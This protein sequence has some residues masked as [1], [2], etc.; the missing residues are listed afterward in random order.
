MTYVEPQMLPLSDFPHSP[1]T[2]PGMKV[3]EADSTP[4]FGTVYLTMP[5]AVKSGRTLRLQIIL[6][7]REN[8]FPEIGDDVYP[9]IFYVQGSAWHEQELGQV[10]PA[11]ADFARRGYVIAIVEYRPSE[12]APFPAQAKDVKRVDVA[13]DTKRRCAGVCACRLI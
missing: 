3:L 6:P 12:V 2:V 4:R 1:A 13:I 5:Y 10:L 8:T 9:T 11:L 7:P